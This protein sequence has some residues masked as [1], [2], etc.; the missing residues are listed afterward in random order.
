[1]VVATKPFVQ[2]RLLRYLLLVLLH[3]RGIMVLQT[4]LLLDRLQHK[5][6]PSQELLL[7][8]VLLVISF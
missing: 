8:A 2:G 4:V 5:I 1:M 7:M 3:I 6:I